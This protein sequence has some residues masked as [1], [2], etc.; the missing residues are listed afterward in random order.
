M[1]KLVFILVT[2]P[3]CNAACE[4]LRILMDSIKRDFQYAT[5]KF[6]EWDSENPGAMALGLNQF[7]A[8]AILDE[9]ASILE[10]LEPAVPG[11]NADI[12]WAWTILGKYGYKANGDAVSLSER[13]NVYVVRN[14]WWLV[15]II[16]TIILALGLLYWK[17]IK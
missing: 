15:L 3:G 6:Q 5:I 14:Q 17:F 9:T 16:L 8:I 10:T 1:Q 7:P 2:P 13:V 4:E 11:Q 12:E